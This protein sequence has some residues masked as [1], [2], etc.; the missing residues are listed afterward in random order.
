MKKTLSEMT[1]EELWH[2]FPIFLTS[3]NTNWNNWYNEEKNRIEKLLNIK[4]YYINHIGST[5]IKNIYAKPIIDIIMEIPKSMQMKEI[6]NFLIKIG[7][8]CMK[9]NDSRNSFC[10]GYTTNGFAEKV[11]HLHLR[12]YNDNDEL[13]F[14]DFMNEFPDLKKEYETLKL[15]LCDK[16]KYDRDGYTIAKS[17]F[18]VKNTNLAKKYYNYKYKRDIK[19]I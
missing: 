3:P 13:Y 17:D 5:S 16:Y 12:Y 15:S 8:T 1:L 18:V 7:Y 11:F 9:E 14:R 2:L 10:L 4:D 6:K 19:L